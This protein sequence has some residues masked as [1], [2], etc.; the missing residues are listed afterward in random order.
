VLLIAAGEGL[1]D[2]YSAMQ[3]IID[4]AVEERK[5]RAQISTAAE[6][7]SGPGVEQQIK[8]TII[9]QPNVVSGLVHFVCCPCLKTF[10]RAGCSASIGI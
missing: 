9:G 4:K 10:Y 3:P 5:A 2:L 8:L 7:G 1:A 6:T